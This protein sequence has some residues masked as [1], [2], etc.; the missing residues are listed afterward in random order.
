MGKTGHKIDG[1]RGL[2]YVSFV[3]AQVYTCEP[4]EPLVCVRNSLVLPWDLDNIYRN[5]PKGENK[6]NQSEKYP[7][8]LLI[9]HRLS[10][11]QQK[12]RYLK[13]KWPQPESC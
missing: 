6:A 1:H 11:D 12:T 5:S 7:K 13:V 2:G 4:W 3:V 8:K 10:L 9:Q